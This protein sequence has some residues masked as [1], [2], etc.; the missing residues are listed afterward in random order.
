MRTLRA[1]SVPPTGTGR[2][3]TKAP[4]HSFSPSVRNTAS[5]RAR[6]PTPAYVQALLYA[7]ACERA[8]TFNPCGV[9]EALEGFEFDGLGNGKTLYR[10]ED[11][12]CFKDVLVVKGKENP[13]SDI[14]PSGNRRSHAGCSGHLS[15][16][17]PAVCGRCTRNLQPG[18]LIPMKTDF[19]TTGRA[20]PVP[21]IRNSAWLGI[22]TRAV[23]PS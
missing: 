17:S 2:F 14:R 3:R 13:S 6:Q 20:R 9:V 5:R 11:H 4:R 15:A 19:Q 16:G 7:D 23:D 21:F 22:L 10:A 18:R 12:Q 8:G 1:S